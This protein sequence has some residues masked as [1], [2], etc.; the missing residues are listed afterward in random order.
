MTRTLSFP[1]ASTRVVG[2]VRHHLQRR[3]QQAPVQD[4]RHGRPEPGGA[5]D[6]EHGRGIQQ[7]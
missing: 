7:H 6:A 4:A 1:P 3:R 5:A 2:A